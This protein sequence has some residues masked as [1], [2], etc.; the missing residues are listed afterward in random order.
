MFKCYFSQP[1]D[2]R[3]IYLIVWRIT[4]RLKK[5]I[6]FFFSREITKK[7]S[8][9]Q[10]KSLKI[11]QAFYGD[12]LFFVSL[13]PSAQNGTFSFGL[14]I[15]CPCLSQRPS[16]QRRDPGAVSVHGGVERRDDG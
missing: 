14:Y 6:L 2:P 1:F 16:E 10:W 12:V 3:K 9:V 15:R 5:K 4:T 8:L 13:L 11:N 7:V